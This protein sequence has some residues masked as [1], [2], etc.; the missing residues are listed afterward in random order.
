MNTGRKC[1]DPACRGDLRDSIINFGESLPEGWLIE[2]S[3]LISTQSGNGLS[4]RVYRH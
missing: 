3:V 4:M 1:D 2:C